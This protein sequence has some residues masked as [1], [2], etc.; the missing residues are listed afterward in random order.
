MDL[1]ESYEG[2]LAASVERGLYCINTSQNDIHLEMYDQKLSR[3][4]S[5]TNSALATS[6]VFILR[7][8][9]RTTTKIDLET[10]V[11]SSLNDLT[12]P[13]AREEF[14][15]RRDVQPAQR[16]SFQYTKVARFLPNCPI[17]WQ[18]VTDEIS[19]NESGIPRVRSRTKRWPRGRRKL[20]SP[21]YVV[22]EMGISSCD[23]RKHVD[24]HQNLFQRLTQKT[25]CLAD[26]YITFSATVRVH[27]E[28]QTAAEESR[29]KKQPHDASEYIFVEYRRRRPGDD[30]R[31]FFGHGELLEK[32][33]RSDGKV[34]E[35]YVEVLKRRGLRRLERESNN[36]PSS[37]A[38]VERGYGK[39][40]LRNTVGTQ[41]GLRRDL[42][43]IANETSGSIKGKEFP[44]KPMSLSLKNSLRGVRLTFQIKITPIN[45]HQIAKKIQHYDD[46]D[47]DED[48]D[49]DD[50][51]NDEDDDD[52]D[53]DD[54][55]DDN[56]EDDGDDD[57][58]NDSD[59][60]DDEDEDDDDDDNYDNDDD[61]ADDGDDDDDTSG[62]TRRIRCNSPHRHQNLCRDE[63][64]VRTINLITIPCVKNARCDVDASARRRQ[65]DEP[66]RPSSP[67]TTT[68]LFRKIRH[69]NFASDNSSSISGFGLPPGRALTSRII[70]Y[71]K[72]NSP[73]TKATSVDEAAEFLGND[74]VR[75]Y[76]NGLPFGTPYVRKAHQNKPFIAL[77]MEAAK[78]SET[79]VKFYQTTRRN[80]PEDSHLRTPP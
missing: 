22:Q 67:R 70:T 25:N 18:I 47:E 56:D 13:G 72:K 77:K 53:S 76:I 37:N 15:I 36:P 12:R 43:N 6:R 50:D 75:T 40:N 54:D 51:D 80:N 7:V 55:D 78:T 48:D 61:D 33:W 16:S 38:S 42:V 3:R 46:D 71:S 1:P 73:R 8:T 64:D 28:P 68:F 35:G 9:L 39:W 32:S 44:Y 19:I 2:L 79:S 10:L 58:D 57:D 30:M 29:C 45:R 26:N 34:L 65:T 74:E 20:S 5:T 31:K 23:G 24:V 49:D 27:F 59:D 21:T 11:F 62:A 4:L 41:T 69:D 17:G 14:I 52:N 66:M 63:Q 60:D